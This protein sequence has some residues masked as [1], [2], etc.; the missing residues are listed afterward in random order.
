[1]AVVWRSSEKC[2]LFLVGRLKEE[3]RQSRGRDLLGVGLEEASVCSL[4]MFRCCF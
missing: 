2:A 4:G 1:M 3:M